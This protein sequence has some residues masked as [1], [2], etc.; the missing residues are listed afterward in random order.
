MPKSS[1]FEFPLLGLGGWCSSRARWYTSL[2]A[3]LDLA[4]D[5]LEVTHASGAGG[6]PSLG[7]LGPV[8]CATVSLHFS[9]PVAIRSGIASGVQVDV[10]PLTLA[11]GYPHDEQVCF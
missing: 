2:E 5:G 1:R 11:A 3:V 8:V 10:H 9:M 7:L 4:G 6:L